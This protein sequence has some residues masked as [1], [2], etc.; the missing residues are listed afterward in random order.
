MIFN[1]NGGGG[2][3][4]L[5][6]TVVGGTSQPS[7]PATNTIWVN[8]STSITSY[9]FSPAQPTGSAGVV[10]FKTL[11]TG[12]TSMN[13]LK[14]NVITLY[15]NACNQYV[16]G[17][18]VPKN[19]KLYTGN[20]WTQFAWERV[21]LFINGDTCNSLTGGWKEV[22][23]SGQTIY[24]TDTNITFTQTAASSRHATLYTNNT[25]DITGYTKLGIKLNITADGAQGA[26]GINIIL[27]SAN[28]KAEPTSFVAKAST[29]T[30]GTS[31]LEV[32]ISSVTDGKYYVGVYASAVTGTASE[33]YFV[34]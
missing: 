12:S 23:S 14:K 16:S 21:H 19:A 22:K 17:K 7:S 1:M 6:F 15:L 32:D 29:L 2:G 26:T 34:Q 33:V 8:T 5:N 4:E 18:W 30:H 9:V 25:V 10:W 24:T 11:T 27:M 28:T 3:S 20:A 31:T 13:A